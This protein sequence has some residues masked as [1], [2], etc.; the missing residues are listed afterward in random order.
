MGLRRKI[1]NEKWLNNQVNRSKGTRRFIAVLLFL[2]L[3]GLVMGSGAETAVAEPE[4][5]MANDVRISQVYGGGSGKV[6][7]AN[8]ATA[9]GCGATATLCTL[10]DARI[11]DLVSYGA[12]NNAEGGVSVNNGTALTN[13]QGGVRKLQGCQ[14][15]DVNNDDFDV[16]SGVA[17]QPRNSSSP[18]NSCVTSPTV[19]GDLSESAY[20]TIATKLNSNSGFG[21][22]IDVTAIKLYRDEANQVLYIG[23]PGKLDTTS[24]NA[25]GLWLDIA[26]ASS[27]GI[28]AGNALGGSGGHY[29]GAAEAGFAADFE[30]DYMFAFNPGSGS[31]FVYFDVVKLVG[32]RTPQYLGSSNQSGAPATSVNSGVFDTGSVTFAFDN[33]GAADKGLE[34]AIPY[35]QIG[36]TPGAS[37]IYA[38]AFV[39]SNTAFF[40]DVTVPGNVPLPDGKNPLENAGN[41]PDFNALAGGPYH[42]GMTPTAVTLSTFSAN[43]SLPLLLL[44]VVGLLVGGTALLGRRR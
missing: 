34:M 23:V 2:A 11:V 36:L 8:I 17:L 42:N 21:A 16:L 38:F 27:T 6:A 29:M 18:T 43:A 25:I 3:F 39:V 12:S 24:N 26:S 15:T 31:T 14:D 35:G 19:N 32:V 5:P 7:L 20:V 9:L 10:P 30:V 28:A 41:N 4:A 44:V 33:S 13:Q 37:N 1:M 22:N 40:S